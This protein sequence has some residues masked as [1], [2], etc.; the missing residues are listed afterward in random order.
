M[1]FCAKESV[2]KAWFPLT[3]QWLDFA[4]LSVT[5]GL[6]GTFSAR[7]CVR[8][9]ILGG[10]D[11]DAFKGRWVVARGLVAAGTSAG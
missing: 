11:L 10:V 3:R 2:Y 7:L 8:G 1:L 6:D 4:D 5:L 9:P